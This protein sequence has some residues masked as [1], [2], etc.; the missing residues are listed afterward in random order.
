LASN[1][2]TV[3]KTIEDS[4]VYTTESYAASTAIAG[5]TI[6]DS[7]EN[8]N[9]TYFNYVFYD[10]VVTESSS[11]ETVLL[12]SENVIDKA[13]TYT[14]AATEEQPEPQPYLADKTRWSSVASEEPQWITID[15]ST[16]YTF[17]E[18]RIVWQ[19][20]N[21]KEYI[22]SVSDDGK[23]F[24]EIAYNT[25]CAANGRYDN[26]KFNEEHTARYIRITGLTR[27]TV[28]GYSIWGV[29]IYGTESQKE[30]DKNIYTISVDG[31]DQSV[32]EGQEYTFGNA[33]YGYYDAEND[34]MYKPDTVVEVNSDITVTS[35]NDLSVDIARGAGIRV[36]AD[37]KGAGIRYQAKITTT[38][39]NVMESA[40]KQGTVIKAGMLITAND[41]YENK[42][43]LIVNAGYVVKDVENS[44]WYKNNTGTYCGSIVN[45]A[46]S[47]YIR[48]FIARAYV[49]FTYS[50]GT[51]ETVYSEMGDVRSIKKVAQAIQAAKYPGLSD[52]AKE[53]VDKYTEAMGD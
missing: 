14:D 25:D 8:D 4:Y 1:G 12:T 37:E 42:G 51:K 32:E 27:N 5:R 50:D 49:T 39:D 24:T 7:F 41:I 22:I 15:L 17:D 9:K 36:V 47:N 40:G 38:N 21:A 3:T 20:A 26:L 13:Q 6:E 23:E 29:G 16:G 2:I 33:E 18:M 28:Y 30:P 53:I 19:T 11:N 48:K 31:V 46:E 34:V 35:V 43:E 44:G 45:I 10:N 52:E